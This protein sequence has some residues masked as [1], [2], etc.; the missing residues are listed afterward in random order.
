MHWYLC[1]FFFLYHTIES[2]AFYIQLSDCRFFICEIIPKF[3][4]NFDLYRKIFFFN[5]QKWTVKQFTY[6]FLLVNRINCTSYFANIF[7]E[8]KQH[9]LIISN[10]YKHYI[11]IILRE[12]KSTQ[13]WLLTLMEKCRIPI[14]Y[15]KLSFTYIFFYFIMKTKE[16]QIV[17]TLY[18]VYL[19]IFIYFAM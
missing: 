16:I 15:E 11:L 7:R 1:I 4:L 12:Y 13:F 19:F 18:A 17:N 6:T 2:C 9:I 3:P 14:V 8:Y 10:K 5:I